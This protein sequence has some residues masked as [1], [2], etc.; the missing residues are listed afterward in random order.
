[1]PSCPASRRWFHSCIVR[2]MMLCPSARS[3]AATVEESTPPDMATAMVWGFG[4]LRANRLLP[5]L[6]RQLPQSRYRLQHQR[7]RDFDVFPGIL[8][9]Q[10]KADAGAGAVRTQSHRREHMGW[11]DG[12][13][14][15]CRACRHCQAFQIESDHHRLALDMVEINARR[16]GYA[17][18]AIAIHPNFFDLRQ[19]S[20]LQAVAQ[21]GHFRVI[22]ALETP[23][24]QLCGF[25][26]RHNSG[27]VLSTS[28]AG[29]LVPSTIKQR[30]RT[31]SLA[32]IERAYSLRRVHFVAGDRERMATNLLHV[33]RNLPC[34]LNRV[35]MKKD[36]G[37][38]C[39]LPDFFN[40]L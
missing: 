25:A 28:P 23:H 33:D 4:M 26:Q 30:P 22:I 37:F 40:G 13:R 20:L 18:R 35:A 9:A 14:R 3:M 5:I 16:I 38:R 21:C 2:P 7:K 39:D 27:N 8:F 6:R 31:R 15:T 34:G 29:T 12:S 11:L 19:N 32:H 1:M 17:R 36:L 10:A 24:S